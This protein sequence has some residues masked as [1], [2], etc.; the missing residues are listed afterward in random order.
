MSSQVIPYAQHPHAPNDP[1]S[2]VWPATLCLELAMRDQTPE[3]VCR[4]YGIDR[5]EFVRLGA[6]PAFRAELKAAV[7]ALR[8]EG[9]SFRVRAQMQSVELLKT[10]FTMIHNTDVPANVRADLI[11]FTV[12]AAGLDASVMASGVNGKG[13]VAQAFTIN[14]NLG[15]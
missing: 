3:E 1:L 11:K 8:K 5:D 2:S 6:N 12:K 7:E 4:A 15:G 13:G 14:L 9:A 10:S